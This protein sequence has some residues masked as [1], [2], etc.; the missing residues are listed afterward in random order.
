MIK[1]N[2]TLTTNTTAQEVTQQKPNA[3]IHYG[4]IIAISAIIALAWMISPFDLIPD[5]VVGLG[6]LDDLLVACI[7]VVS[8]LCALKQHITAKRSN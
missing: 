5:I 4:W 8:S 1:L 6:Q 2:Q 3:K 7:P